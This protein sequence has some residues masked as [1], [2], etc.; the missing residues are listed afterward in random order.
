[1]IVSQEERPIGPGIEGAVVDC[2]SM[3]FSTR[4]RRRGIAIASAL[5]RSNM[6]QVSRVTQVT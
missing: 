1:L 4:D 3:M 2:E 6:T 5:L